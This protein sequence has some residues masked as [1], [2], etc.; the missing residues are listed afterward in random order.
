MKYKPLGTKLYC[1]NRK[2]L[3]K[4]LKP[5]SVVILKSNDLMPTNADGIFPFIQNTDLFFLTG[6]DQEETT[7]IFYPDH[8]NPD[9]QAVLVL[10]KT[11]ENIAI[12]EGKKL[13]KKMAKTYSGIKTIYWSDGKNILNNVLKP[14]ICRAEHI[15]LNTN[16]H[17]RAN[18][19]IN[20]A[21][22]R[23]ISACKEMY[24]LH[25]Y[26]RLAPLLHQLRAVKQLQEIKAIKKAI[27]ITGIAFQKILKKTHIGIGEHEI[28]ALL[29]YHFLKNKSQ[30]PGYQPIVASGANS[31]V[32]HYIDNNQIC[33]EGDLLLIDIGAK[34]ANYSADITR[35]IPVSGRFN[36]RQK[37]V[38]MAVLA[39]KSYAENLLQTGNHLKTYHEEIGKFAENQLINL[40]LLTSHEVKKQDKDKPLYKKYFMHGTSHHLG[41]DI[42]DYGQD[43][44]RKFESGMVFTCEPGIYIRDENIGI[45][46]EDNILITKK[47]NQNL[48]QHIPIEIEDLEN[49]MN[50]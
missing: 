11:D 19:K 3:A 36:E 16:E 1:Q 27:K 23:L 8:P 46:L 28:E 2:R 47:G 30:M 24:P 42:H 14:F 31:C 50:A 21:N 33:K 41:L 17:L 4:L 29:I 37:Q 22:D 45:R 5:N 48:S 35:T 13:D 38:Y 9:L 40:K 34:Y 39:I 12:W 6:I 20:S 44:Y 7:F 10:R 43:D 25:S 26:Q 49:I 15:Y 32:L 18:S